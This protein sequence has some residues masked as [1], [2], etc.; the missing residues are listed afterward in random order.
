M[1]APAVGSKVTFA[2]WTMRRD[3]SDL[4]AYLRALVI[5]YTAAG[6]IEVI[7]VDKRREALDYKD[8]DTLN[9]VEEGVE[10]CR[11]WDHK[12]TRALKTVRTL[13]ERV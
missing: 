3:S 2:K 11:G 12:R 6:E 9:L 7:V 13:Q 5:G 8:F 4:L 1:S 10:W